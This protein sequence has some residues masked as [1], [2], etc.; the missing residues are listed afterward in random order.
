MPLSPC[1]FPS[2]E[3]RADRWH[4]QRLATWP[5]ACGY[6]AGAWGGS[7]VGTAHLGLPGLRL[8]LKLLDGAAQL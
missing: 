3:G 5:P 6:T 8:L 2:P 1:A 7:G 4:R